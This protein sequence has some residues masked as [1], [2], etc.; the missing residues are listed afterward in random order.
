MQMWIDVVDGGHRVTAADKKWTEAHEQK[1]GGIVGL[2]PGDNKM[3]M[4]AVIVYADTPKDVCTVLSKALNR[5]NKI[6]EKGMPCCY[7]CC[8][9]FL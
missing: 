1:V 4:T 7:S 6:G 5:N 9:L 2:Q 8:H 3:S